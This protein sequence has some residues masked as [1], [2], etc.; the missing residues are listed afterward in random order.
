MRKKKKK[1]EATEPLNPQEKLGLWMPLSTL[2]S[3][4]DIL[5]DKREFKILIN[6]F[7]LS[8][9]AHYS[10]NQSKNMVQSKSKKILT[11][12]EKL[13]RLKG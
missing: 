2:L 9:S 12:L 11:K 13:T 1:K 6:S 10:V 4:K 3:P 5:I 8:F 7:G